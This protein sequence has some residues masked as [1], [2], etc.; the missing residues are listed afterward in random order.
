MKC[1]WASVATAFMG[2]QAYNEF[3]RFYFNNK[4]MSL[5]NEMNVAYEAAE[6]LQIDFVLDDADYYKDTT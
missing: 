3:D 5:L 1:A 4:Q 2:V 6:S